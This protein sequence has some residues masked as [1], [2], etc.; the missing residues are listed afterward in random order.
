MGITMLT[1]ICKCQMFEVVLQCSYIN[2][3]I[4]N[5]QLIRLSGHVN[6]MKEGNGIVA[7]T[8]LTT[9]SKSTLTILGQSRRPDRLRKKNDLGSIS[10]LHL[11]FS[12]SFPI[13]LKFICGMCAPGFLTLSTSNGDG[14]DEN[15]RYIMITFE[16]LYRNAYVFCKNV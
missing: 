2:L 3:D 16:W 15:I 1:N 4:V 6:G 7:V 10:H 8:D 12:S 13:N 9:C 14:I 5:Q 11:G